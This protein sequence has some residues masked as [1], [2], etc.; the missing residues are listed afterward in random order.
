MTELKCWRHLLLLGILLILSGLALSWTSV[1]QAAAGPDLSNERGVDLLP[2]SLARRLALLS[3]Q[4]RRNLASALR[5]RREPGGLPDDVMEALRSLSEEQRSALLLFLEPPAAPAQEAVVSAAASTDTNRDAV[6]APSPSIENTGET[7]GLRPF[8]Y[9]LFTGAASTFAPAMDI[10]V[11]V[12]YVIGPGDVVQ[13]QLFGKENAQFDLTVSRDGTLNFPNIGPVPVAGMKFSELRA[14]IEQRVATQ[15]IG[16][17]ANVTLGALRSIR[18]FVLGEAVRPGSYTVSA[19]STLTN[20]LLASGGIKPIGSLRNIQL[21]RSGEIVATLDLYD[22]LLRGDTRNDARLQPGDVIFVPPVGKTVGIAGA[23]RRPAVY[24]LTTEHSVSDLIALAGGLEP[25]A[26]TAGTQLERIDA[27]QDRT[28]VD[29]DL[30]NAASGRFE[31]NNGDILRVPSVLQQRESSV[32]LSGHVLRPGPVPWRKGMR[33]SQIVRSTRELKPRPDT[34]YVLIL[35]EQ[36]PTRNLQVLSADLGGA[37][38]HPRGASDLLLQPGDEVLVLGLDEDRAKTLTPVIFQLRQQTRNGGPEPVVT[39]SGNLRH[40]GD[41]PLVGG[42]TVRDA[43]RANL[44]VLPETDLEY[45]L[46]RREV[47]GGRRVETIAIKLGD[48]LQNPRSGANVQLRPRDELYVFSKA[49]DRQELLAPILN[50]LQAQAV[51]GDGAAIVEIDGAVRKPGRYPLNTGMR[52]ADLVEVAGGL[53]ES[54]YS[55][56]AELNRFAVIEGKVREVDHVNFA[57]RDALDGRP[58]TNVLLQPHDRL[59]IKPV[60]N[61]GEAESVELV[62]EVRF[63]G[64]YTIRRGETLSS[65]LRRAGGLTTYAFPRGAVFTRESLRQREQ[66]EMDKLAARIEAELAQSQLE[67][68]QST[69]SNTANVDREAI[70]VSRSVVQQIRSTKAIGRLVI[71][72]PA[73]LAGPEIAGM[74]REEYE[75]LDVSLKPGDR[76]VV[77]RDTQEVT[78]LGE[79]FH[80]TSH[81]YRSDLDRDD[82][83]RQSGGTT[84]KADLARIYIVRANGQVDTANQGFF[85]SGIF[86]RSATSIQPGDTIIVPLDVERMKPL[87]FWSEVTKIIGQVGLTVAAFHS[88]GAL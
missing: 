56:G 60:T 25:A 81:L 36:R 9:D 40:P 63:P 70:S 71:N 85:S 13:I 61:W 8:G 62:G 66:D 51:R 53:A 64:N 69:D 7:G 77:P 21:K 24:E 54:A 23:V 1:S 67:R 57:L 58:D 18:V 73:L 30:N 32:T 65:V 38:A 29:L 15:M 88:V 26:Y 41:Y 82:Y 87:A 80:G 28:L 39:L 42:M 45:A 27:H 68:T 76:L 16:M 12:D 6:V 11:P 17:R 72:L 43:I 50:E 20:A 52:I 74:S 75:E 4:D 35:R 59:V 49:A 48:A 34:G 19:L 55:L 79:V 86:A 83:I 5:E 47:E 3:L 78:V 37:L 84:P 14:Q 31:L 2:S 44:D 22:L 33:L 10:P 46:L